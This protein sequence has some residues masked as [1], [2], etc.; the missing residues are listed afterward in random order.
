MYVN[1]HSLSNLFCQYTRWLDETVRRDGSTHASAKG[2]PHGLREQ[3]PPKGFHRRA[4][5]SHNAPWRTLMNVMMN[6]MMDVM[7]NV[8]TK[9]LCCIQTH[10]VYIY[11]YIHIYRYCLF[12]NL[13][14]GFSEFNCPVLTPLLLYY[15]PLLHSSTAPLFYTRLYCL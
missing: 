10:G 7:M 9:V 4:R 15:T 12:P 11:I 5:H 3:L 14:L 8:M 1:F 6:V 13:W 2:F